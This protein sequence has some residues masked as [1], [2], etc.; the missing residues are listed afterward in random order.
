MHDGTAAR[1]EGPRPARAE[2]R[3]DLIE[4]INYI[5][6]TSRGLEPTIGIDWPHV[7]EP[8]NF[9]NVRVVFDPANGEKGKLV[10]STAVWTS[11][12]TIGDR[13]LRVGGINCVGTLPEYRQ[14][15]LGSQVMAA[16]HQVMADLGC[17]V[18]LLSTGIANWYRRLGWEEAGMRRDYHFNRGNIM[19]LPP[20]AAGLRLRLVNVADLLHDDVEVARLLSLYHAASM[21]AARTPARFRQLIIARRG[22]RAALAESA[23]GAVAYLL[24]REQQIIEWAGAAE[25]VAGLVRACFEALDDH[26][27]STTQRAAD[28]RPAS[29]RRLTLTTPGWPHPLVNLLDQRRIPFAQE[30]L[31]MLYLVNPQAI[32]DAYGL[33]FLRL[34]NSSEDY[35]LRDSTAEIRLN[36]RQLTKFIFGPERVSEMAAGHFPLPFWQWP[37]EMV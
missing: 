23:S 15:G 11:D 1:L 34:E 17:H 7:Y 30:Y 21:G 19:L 9:A 3:D 27:A 8:E 25:Q 6:R 35:L 29:L 12:V 33:S 37:I 28:N 4:M 22:E 14:H 18:G 32:L 5:F 2:E 13:S 26:S 20:L 10:A 16:A 31:G 24:L 36:R